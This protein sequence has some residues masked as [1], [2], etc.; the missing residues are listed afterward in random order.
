MRKTVLPLASLVC[1]LGFASSAAANY[2]ITLDN[3]GTSGLPTWAGTSG[4]ITIET[5]INGTWD[6]VCVLEPSSRLENHWCYVTSGFEW[7]DVDGIRISTDSG[8]GFWLDQFHLWEY[9]GPWDYTVRRTWG[10]DNN[11]GWCFSTDSE[12]P[13]QYCYNGW[14]STRTW[15]W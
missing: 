5:K 11:T 7:D 15:T 4:D 10:I 6:D 1:T 8:D 13:S 2:A 12:D 9:N 3:Y 14:A